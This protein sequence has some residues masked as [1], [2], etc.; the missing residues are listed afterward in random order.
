MKMGKRSRITK[1]DRFAEVEMCV[2]KIFF[3][4][5]MIILMMILNDA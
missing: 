3:I 1:G 4:R 2:L 5:F